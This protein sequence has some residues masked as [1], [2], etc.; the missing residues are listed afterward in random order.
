MMDAPQYMKHRMCSFM[1]SSGAFLYHSIVQMIAANSVTS[2][3]IS[4]P[5]YAAAE[6]VSGAVLRF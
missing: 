2:K 3:V 6:A 5:P 1:G 4:T